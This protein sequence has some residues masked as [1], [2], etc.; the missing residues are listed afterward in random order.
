MLGTINGIALTDAVGPTTGNS[1]NN[2]GA[3]AGF[4]AF[5]LN[6][7][8]VLTATGTTAFTFTGVQI[9]AVAV[10]EPSSFAL[11]GLGLVGLATRRRR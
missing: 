3:T 9:S 11:L 7:E 5:A 2:Q 6:D 1:G 4:Q 10:P 8:F